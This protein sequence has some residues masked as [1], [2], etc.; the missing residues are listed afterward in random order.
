[1]EVGTLLGQDS[2]ELQKELGFKIGTISEHVAVLTQ[3][4]LVVNE[5]MKGEKEQNVCHFGL[6][7]RHEN[8]KKKHSIPVG[9]RNL[10]YQNKCSKS[11][12]EGATS[13]EVLREHD[14]IY[15]QVVRSGHTL[16]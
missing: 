14:K 9:Q 8:S 13:S 11:V 6:H 3:L 5:L 7:R 4:G 16:E 10:C 2:Y 1:M 12:K 15:R